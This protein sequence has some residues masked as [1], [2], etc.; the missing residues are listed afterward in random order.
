MKK[1]HSELSSALSIFASFRG[2]KELHF[3]MFK[4]CELA[5][6]VRVGELSHFYSFCLILN[7][8]SA[9]ELKEISVYGIQISPFIVRE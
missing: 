2:K 5:V 8:S 9:E 4:S 3:C 1:H 6:R 7:E